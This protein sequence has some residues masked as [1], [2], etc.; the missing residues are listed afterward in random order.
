MIWPTMTRPTDSQLAAAPIFGRMSPTD[1]ALIAGVSDVRSYAPGEV[2]FN[3]GDP[4][5]L[6]LTILSG[7]VRVSSSAGATP[8]LPEFLH[9]GDPLGDVGAFEGGPYPA[10]A[11]AVERDR[12]PVDPTV[13]AVPAAGAAPHDGARLRARID[14]A[15]RAAHEGTQAASIA[16]SPITNPPITNP[17]ITGRQIDL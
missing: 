16:D 4:A 9:A 13:R 10:S 7:R 6:I 5:A 14:A 2:V 3:E 8:E 11:V 15:N 12:V 1:R 17:P